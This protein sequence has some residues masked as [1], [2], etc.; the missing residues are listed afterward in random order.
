MSSKLSTVAHFLIAL[1]VTAA[2]SGCAEKQKPLPP[3]KASP[4]GLGV[5]VA[6]P[7]VRVAAGTTCADTVTQGAAERFKAAAVGA[8][9]RA[10][11]SVVTDPAEQ[12]FTAAL[13]LEVDYCSDAGIVS[14]TTAM[15]LQRKTGASVWR[16]QAV[17][18][19]ARGETASSTMNE[20]IETML[21]DA[22]VIK[23]TQDARK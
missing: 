22:R 7:T 19:Q 11:F 13:D 12:A 5:V 15:E 14:G 16:G 8:L 10:G 1:A 4:E 23:A 18:D 2:V 20:L 6:V 21:Y 3:A 17:G 9:T